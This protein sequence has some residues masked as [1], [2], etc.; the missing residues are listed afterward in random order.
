MAQLMWTQADVAAG[1]APK[2][3][4]QCPKC[5]NYYHAKRPACPVCNPETVVVLEKWWDEPGRKRKQCP[6]CKKYIGHSQEVCPNCQAA[7]PAQAHK[8]GGNGG[9]SLAVDVPNPPIALDTVAPTVDHYTPPSALTP[10]A[11]DENARR[12][13]RQLKNEAEGTVSFHSC[14]CKKRI[15][16]AVGSMPNDKA[17]PTFPADPAD[18]NVLSWAGRVMN[19]GHER[20]I[21]ITPCALRSL[22]LHALSA[23]PVYE[24]VYALLQNYGCRM[25]LPEETEQTEDNTVVK[26]NTAPAP[27]LVK[28]SAAVAKA[29]LPDDECDHVEDEK[30]FCMNCGEYVGGF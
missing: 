9:G 24:R 30:G 2:A 6:S 11:Y 17:S 27:A 28:M 16:Y 26:A 12:W 18:E 7:Q 13:K 19:W 29:T 25:N 15:V 3:R 23:G 22:A 10:R 20:D 8:N 14:G 1:L 5:S 21:H 4:R